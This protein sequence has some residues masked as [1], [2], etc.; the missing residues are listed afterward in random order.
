M[1]AN[2]MHEL[3]I[4]LEDWDGNTKYA[5]YSNFAIGNQDEGFPLRVLG[6]Y[7]GTAGKVL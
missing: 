3:L 2:Q 4:H 1:T 5:R 7:D 6:P